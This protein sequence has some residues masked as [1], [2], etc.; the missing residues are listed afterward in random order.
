M[1]IY[2]S[3]S[4]IFTLSCRQG[5]LWMLFDRVLVCVC[6]V[7]GYLAHEMLPIDKLYGNSSYQIHAELINYF[8]AI[9]RH[10]YDVTVVTLWLPHLNHSLGF[11]PEPLWPRR[12]VRMFVAS[13][14][15][16]NGIAEEKPSPRKQ[17]KNRKKKQNVFIIPI[18]G[19]KLETGK[20]QQN[21]F[22]TFHCQKK[23]KKR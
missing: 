18:V 12:M 6:V 11:E 13:T 5:K 4:L 14:E 19:E 20:F 16:P 10:W 17:E 22:P 15:K 3:L 21:A 9:F 1:R 7:V 2:L 23:R 8:R